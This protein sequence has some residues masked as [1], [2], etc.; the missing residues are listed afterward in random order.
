M[1]NGSC[2]FA[3]IDRLTEQLRPYDGII[4]F[5]GGQLMDTAKV[6]SDR[7]NNVLI[8]VQTVPS[9]CAA[10]TTKS[11]VYSPTTKSIVYSP[12]HEMIAS[13]REKKPVDAVILE[14]ELLKNAPLEYLRSGIGDT[15]AKYYEIRRRL[16]DDK[17]HSLSLSLARDLIER[18]REEMLK[19][20]DPRTLNGLDLQNFIDT[21][22]LVA[23]LVDGFA[24]L[25]GRSVAA[26]TFY[27]AYVKV[28]GPQRFT[29]GE[30][31][32]LGNL[33]QVTLENDTAL[34]K[35]IRAYYPRVGLPLSLADLGVTQAEQLNSLAEYMAK[36]DNVR[37]QSIF[38]GITAT[39][40]RKT[41]TKLV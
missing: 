6:V 39:T 25:D 37:I 28:I 7:L 2:E 35:E 16:T 14:P 41:L 38:P 19:M 27:N 24:D 40:I 1:F 15:L 21:I 22:F 18:C 30:I 10:F 3:E 23:S 9:N 13:V 36:P 33:F 26:H 34:I 5:G 11:I 29:H 17:M 32:A 12:T 31:V 8:N 4:A 20:N